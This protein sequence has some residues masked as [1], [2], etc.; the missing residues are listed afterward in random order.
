MPAARPA[1]RLTPRTNEV[2]ITI[3]PT[4]SSH[5]PTSLGLGG[6]SPDLVQFARPSL[7]RINTRRAQAGFRVL[8]AMAAGAGAPERRC[9]QAICKSRSNN[10]SLKRPIGLAAPE[11]NCGS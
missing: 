6:T 1:H 10:P 7:F 11:Q 5:I 4:G 2:A 3:S 9:A 8:Q